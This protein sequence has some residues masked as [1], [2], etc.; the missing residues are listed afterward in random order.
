MW[1]GVNMFQT[2][3][4]EISPE[5]SV[6]ITCNLLVYMGERPIRL[7]K[8]DMQLKVAYIQK[9]YID[10]KVI[11]KKNQTWTNYKNGW[12]NYESLALKTIGKILLDY[13]KY[14]SIFTL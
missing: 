5:G 13:H 1:N 8:E 2:M 9:A 12:K 14:W 3:E 11:G 10:C 6:C 7:P 4:W